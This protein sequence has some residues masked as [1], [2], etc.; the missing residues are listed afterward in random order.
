[1]A[2]RAMTRSRVHP[3]HPPRTTG[4]SCQP[5]RVD[6]PRSSLLHSEI[7]CD[8]KLSPSPATHPVQLAS[9]A[10]FRGQATSGL[11]PSST[12]RQAVARGPINLPR[13]R[14]PQQEGSSEIQN[15]LGFKFIQAIL[16]GEIPARSCLQSKNGSH[17]SSVVAAD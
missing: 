15:R 12:A 1:M 5:S 2:R 8:Q 17:P 7:C 13:R 4:E 9:R 10:H 11:H 6:H 14:N 16:R 3:G